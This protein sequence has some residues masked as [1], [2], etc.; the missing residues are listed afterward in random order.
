MEHTHIQALPQIASCES[1]NKDEFLTRFGRP[2]IPFMLKN[3]VKDTPAMQKWDWDFFAKQYGTRPV[4]V[5]RTS[6]RNRF[7]KMTFKEYIDYI[8]NNED[9]DPLYLLDWFV[10]TN[11]PELV[12]DYSVPQYFDSWLDKFT[13]VSKFL[14]FYIGPKNSASKLH[15]DIL[16]TNAWNAV[17]RGQ[18][19]WVF[20]PKDQTKFIYNGKVNPFKPNY[21]KYPLFKQ[22]KGFYVL[23]NP[24]DL[25]F[26]PSNWWH[27]VYNTEHTLSLTDNFINSSN[28]KQVISHFVPSTLHL[29]KRSWHRRHQ[30]YNKSGI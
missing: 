21:E 26:T 10:G 14:A 15:I 17:F 22:A 8:H 11:C 25:V 12:A 30:E 27:G 23:Q 6:N 1:L 5:Y 29:I 19:L 13:P 28:I 18:K 3:G 4:I 7:E 16:S 9:T 24:G 2:N 20:Y